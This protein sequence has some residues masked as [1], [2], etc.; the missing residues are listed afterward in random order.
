MSSAFTSAKTRQFYK[1]FQ[2]DPALKFTKPSPK[3]RKA[4]SS[5][6]NTLAQR[7]RNAKGQREK[8]I[9]DKRSRS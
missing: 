6:K 9:T 5:R 2:E 1:K 3:N 8:E 7:Q 4:T